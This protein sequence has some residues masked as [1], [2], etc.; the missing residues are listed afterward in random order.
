METVKNNLRALLIHLLGSIAFLVLL[1]TYVVASPLYKMRLVS[2]LVM[3]LLYVFILAVY[4]GVL[5]NFLKCQTQKTLEYFSGILVM[6]IGSS[7]WILTYAYQSQYLSLFHEN[8]Q[9]IPYNVYNYL[10]WP[11]MY[12]IK[13]PFILLGLGLLNGLFPPLALILKRK[14]SRHKSLDKEA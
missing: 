7:I 8:E 2:I 11:I 6:L 1:F 4:I 12:G 14:S 3:G 13:N 5:K 9:W 10:I